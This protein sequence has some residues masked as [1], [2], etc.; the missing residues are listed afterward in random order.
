M[1]YISSSFI[2]PSLYL[3]YS[4]VLVTGP[5]TIFKRHLAFFR[6]VSL[7][8][9]LCHVFCAKS[10]LSFKSFRASWY[11]S[12]Y[13]DDSLLFISDLAC[14]SICF[15]YSYTVFMFFYLIDLVPYLCF[16]SNQYSISSMLSG[17]VNYSS[18]CFDVEKSYFLLFI[19]LGCKFIL[20]YFKLYHYT[21]IP[22]LSL[23]HI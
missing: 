22:L 11:F 17:Y 14:F 10:L 3:I 4:F 16:T 19:S 6:L 7:Y 9:F 1:N 15:I 5:F 12:I 20:S 18:K 23:I 21:S 13:C 2:L 8:N